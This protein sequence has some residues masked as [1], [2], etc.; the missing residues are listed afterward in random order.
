MRMLAF[1]DDIEVPQ[2]LRHM[3]ADG[4][5]GIVCSSVR[6]Y[7]YGVLSKL[8]ES[9]DLSLWILPRVTDGEYP[10]LSVDVQN[11]EADPIVAGSSSMPLRNE[12][13]SIC[14]S[15]GGRC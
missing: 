10:Q 4:G 6:P 11:L 5:V 13:F 9:Q 8:A 12:S 3:P 15:G 2:S 1:G 7:E 14:P